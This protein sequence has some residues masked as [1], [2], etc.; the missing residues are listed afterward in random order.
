MKLLNNAKISVKI[1]AL[2]AVLGTV[3]L[4][5][6]VYSHSSTEKANARFEDVINNDLPAMA[7]VA[8]ANEKITAML[9]SA[10]KAFAYDGGSAEAK[11]AVAMEQETFE[12][13]ASHLQTALKLVPEDAS[14]INAM[15][16]ATKKLHD[17]T[18]KAS[19]L[20][21]ANQNDQAKAMLVDADKVF[22]E[23][24]VEFDKY[25]TGQQ[26]DA[27]K[28]GRDVA[29]AAGSGANTVL[30]VIA[31]MLALSIAA[32]AF[33]SRLAITGP[34][35]QLMD[36]MRELAAG[37]AAIDVPHAERRD[38]VG[39]MAGA[40]KVFRDAA[41]A[42]QA[43]AAEKAIA[44]ADQQRVVSE[45]AGKLESLAGGDLRAQIVTDFPGSYAALKENFN[46][47]TTR[48]HDMI[49]AVR[50]SSDSINIGSTE[51]AKA[52]EDLARRTEQNAAS[53]EET[54]AAMT[55]IDQRVRAS[56]ETSARTV[57][58]ADQ[59]IGTVDSGRQV[60]DRAM[61]AMTR[62]SD[63]AKGIDSV[64][65]GLDKI[66]FQTRV[67]AMNAAVEAGRAGD[68]GKGF[69]V[70]ADL[71]SALAKRAEEE[72]KRARDQLTVTQTEIV[73]AVDAVQKVDGALQ[74]ISQDVAEVHTL[75]GSM[76]ADNQ[77]QSSAISQINISVST[78]D[79]A[80]Q[81]NAAMVEETSAAARNL[82]TEVTS[83]TGQ[84]SAFQVAAARGAAG[85]PKR[86]PAV[87]TTAPIV[88]PA[89]RSKH[90]ASVKAANVNTPVKVPPQ[91]ANGTNGAGDWK[92]F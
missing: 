51:I 9:Y 65:Q 68:A 36:K 11:A 89:S 2:M 69:A 5:G 27:I 58:C 54:S 38:E 71:V 24:D 81:Q 49:C 7:E 30:V 60:A 12:E 21:L 25:E 74:N 79:Q 67:L 34:L 46:Q 43:A 19:A 4:G 77:A 42:Q 47:A 92:D 50:E 83:L 22:H 56:V 82:M 57:S 72:A 59:A 16:A 44:D 37:N 23:I 70:V 8:L 48:L 15:I 20:G 88:L 90:P 55:E 31:V 13:A 62:V 1:M 29:G 40:L 84:A 33:I 76:A 45:V 26:Q 17:L 39:Q 73:T 14:D 35:G 53:L 64:I 61:Q 32:A 86:S 52:S 66:A 85:A 3:F 18:N 10:Y 87:Q 91:K 28:A 80:I 41:Q 78:M 75:L 6:G 63:S